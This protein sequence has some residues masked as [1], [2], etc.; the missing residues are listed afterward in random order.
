MA[1][2]TPQD[3]LEQRSADYAPQ[4]YHGYFY[5]TRNRPFFSMQI[6]RDMLTD[7]RIIFGLWLIKGPIIANARFEIDT[8]NDELGEFIDRNLTRFWKNSAARALKAIEW[9]YSG[10]EVIYR[11]HDNKIHFD[12]LKDFDSPDV[13]V[14]TVNGNVKGMTVRNVRS[15]EALM[16]NGIYI[17]GPKKFWHVV[18]REKHPW[19][20][21]SRLFGAHVPWWEQWSDG[22]YRDGRRLWFYKNAFEGGSMYHPPGSSRLPNGQL[23]LNKDLAREIIEK[24]RTGGVM[25]FSNATSGEGMRQG[26]YIPPSPASVPAGLLEYGDALRFEILEGMGI[27]NEVIESSGEEGFGSASGRQVP[28]MAFFSILQELILWLVADF[29]EQVLRPVIGLNYGASQMDNYEIDVLPIIDPAMDEMQ[30][31]GMGGEEEE[32]DEETGKPEGADTKPPVPK[33][34]RQDRD[35]VTRRNGSAAT[36]TR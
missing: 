15:G 36:A 17:G 35:K 8:D 10:S 20:G 22:G 25:T 28:K 33:A 31:M 2:V 5:I 7:P 23:V 21:Q 30:G 16:N 13:R 4:G 27:P 24:K 26:E 6:I 29:D 18:A 34:S 12:I 32:V 19:Y 1:K 14:I 11:M 3:L 9:G